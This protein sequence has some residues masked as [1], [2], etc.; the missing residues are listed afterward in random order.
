MRIVSAKGKVSLKYH[1]S[2]RMKNLIVDF[3][4]IELIFLKGSALIYSGLKKI[5]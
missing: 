3:D 4:S 1:A 5:T 2:P